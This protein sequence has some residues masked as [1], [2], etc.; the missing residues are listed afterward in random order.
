[1][2]L[3]LPP[4]PGIMPCWPRP[5]IIELGTLRIAIN[6]HSPG[7]T[8]K[9]LLLVRVYVIKSNEAGYIIILKISRNRC[10]QCNLHNIN[11][12]NGTIPMKKFYSCTCGKCSLVALFRHICPRAYD[13]FVPYL[14]NTTLMSYYSSDFLLPAD[15]W[16][17][18]LSNL[19]LLTLGGIGLPLLSQDSS[20]CDRKQCFRLM[21]AQPSTYLQ[22]D[23]CNIKSENETLKVFNSSAKQRWLF[24][25]YQ[26]RLLN[27]SSGH[28][29][30]EWNTNDSTTD[31]ADLANL[32]LLLLSIAGDIEL[33]PGPESGIYV[34]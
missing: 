1:M 5:W 15:N 16:W 21:G 23:H 19:A 29:L 20:T 13:A 3:G 27:S 24:Q 12:K 30:L 8:S 2:I 31:P 28:P 17:N 18:I 33:N 22:D 9:C 4:S 25:N 26:T 6:W 32:T 7:S 10:T 34:I 14:Q 11:C